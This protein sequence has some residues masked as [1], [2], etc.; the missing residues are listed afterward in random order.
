MDPASCVRSHIDSCTKAHR[1]MNRNCS[2]RNPG[3][4]SLLNAFV[5]ILQESLKDPVIYMI[6]LGS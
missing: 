3:R 5:R 1:M 4:N 6:H 2:V